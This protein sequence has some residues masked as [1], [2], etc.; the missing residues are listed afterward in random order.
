MS[1]NLLNLPILLGLPETFVKTIGI[2]IFYDLLRVY[3]F[4]G[5][6][7]PAPHSSPRDPYPMRP[8]PR[9]PCPMGP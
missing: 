8:V 9:E 2:V 5:P 1:F 6:P 4:V 7:T 3:N